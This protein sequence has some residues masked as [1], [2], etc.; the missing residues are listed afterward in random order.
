MITNDQLDVLRGL[1][2]DARFNANWSPAERDRDK[3]KSQAA[4]LAA[5]IATIE[6]LPV[7]RDGVRVVPGVDKVYQ[8]GERIFADGRAEPDVYEHLAPGWNDPYAIRANAEAER[9][10]RAAAKGAR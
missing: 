9:D 8:V 3:S 7:T 4:A 10:R 2:G 1:L 5:A 6:R